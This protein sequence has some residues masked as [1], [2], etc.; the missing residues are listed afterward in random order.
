[1]MRAGDLGRLILLSAIWGSSYLLIE[2][3]LEDLSPWQ[4]VAGRLVLGAAVLV[5]LLLSRG[6][7]L[8]ADRSVWRALAVMAI[9]SNIVPFALITWGQE[10]ITSSLASVLNSTVPLF[11]AGIAAAVVPGERLTAMRS[12]GIIIGFIGVGVIVGVDVN[13]SGGDLAGEVAIVLASLSYAIGFVFAKRRLTGRAGS[14]LAFAA[15]QLALGAA[16]ALVPAGIATAAQPGVPGAPAVLA[17]AALGA[18]GTG[19]AYVLYYRLIAD[20]GPTTASFVTYLL[21]VYGVVLGW[22]LL[23]ETIGWNTLVGAA[24]VIGGITI[25]ERGARGRVERELQTPMSIQRDGA[26]SG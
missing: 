17:V 11:T 12:A 6:G 15:G 3:G 1:M 22:A 4:I 25:S 9:V 13:G 14:P 8:P 5:A 7:S 18:L 26:E 20:V 19:V 2:I 10:S 23:D 21:P 16:F 24:L